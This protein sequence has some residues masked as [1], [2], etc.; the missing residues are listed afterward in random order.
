MGVLCLRDLTAN[1]DVC[2]VVSSH[3]R[4]SQGKG[5]RF[6]KL[7]ERSGG[8]HTYI[9]INLSDL[10]VFLNGIENASKG[11]KVNRSLSAQ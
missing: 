4:S 8:H 3:P 7:T 6:L 11:E 1:L 5:E 10:G 2:I 9:S